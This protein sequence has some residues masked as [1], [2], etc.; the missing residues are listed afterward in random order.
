MRVMNHSWS[1]MKQRLHPQ[2][3][4]EISCHSVLSGTGFDNVGHRLG[5]ATRTQITVCKSPFPSAGTTVSLLSELSLKTYE[6]RQRV[7][8]FQLPTPSSS[9]LDSNYFMRMLFKNIGCVL[10][11]GSILWCFITALGMLYYIP[12][13]RHYLAAFCLLFYIILMNEW[14][15]IIENGTI[16]KLWYGFLFEFHSNYGH[17]FSCFN[18]IHERDRD[19][20]TAWQQELLVPLCSIITVHNTA[21]QTILLIFPLLQ[22]ITSQMWPTGRKRASMQAA[23]QL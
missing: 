18:T 22:T 3:V 20:A 12:S 16:R 8:N 2:S 1:A 13:Y 19:P 5:L 6:L 23:H 11:T 14:M 9:L 7:H 17:I 15:K 4:A 10:P 21:A